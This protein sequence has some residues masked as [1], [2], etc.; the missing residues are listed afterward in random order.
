MNLILGKLMGILLRGQTL[1]VAKQDKK[2]KPR[3]HAHKRMVGF[4]KK[5]GPNS[6]EK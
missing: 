6:F 2:K 5:R 1:K 3:G 4:G